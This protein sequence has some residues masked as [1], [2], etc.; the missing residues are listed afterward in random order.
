MGSGTW[1]GVSSYGEFVVLYYNKAL[2]KKAGVKVPATWDEFEAALPLL[3]ALGAIPLS[4]GAVNYPAQHLL[5]ELYLSR[6]TRPEVEDFQFYRA[7]V[8]FHSRAWTTAAS[9]LASWGASGYFSPR[10]LALDD[11]A[12][13]AEFQEGKSGFMVSGTWFFSRL[14]AGDLDWGTVLFPGNRFHPGSGGNLW[15]VPARSRH[16]DWAVEFMDLTLGR[17]VQTELANAGGL[18]VN[19]DPGRITN[20]RAA[21]LARAFG[22]VMARDGLAFYPDWPALGFYDSLVSACRDLLKGVSPARVLDGLDVA[23]RTK[24]GRS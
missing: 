1:Y 17:E 18:A 23:Y 24:K 12:M 22:Q 2:L 5:Y 13:L 10:A 14:A 20:P 21:E 3:K 11:E 7:P 4:L 15:V 8:D 16:P 19:A 6:A 9:T